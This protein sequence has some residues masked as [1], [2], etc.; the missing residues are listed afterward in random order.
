VVVVA[1]HPASLLIAQVTVSVSAAKAQYRVSLFSAASHP[2]HTKP[3]L[4]LES[5]VSA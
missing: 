3:Y 2:D 4:A 1:Q 5:S